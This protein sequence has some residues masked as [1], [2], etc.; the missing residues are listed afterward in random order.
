MKTY[1][2][3]KKAVGLI[4]KVDGLIED[5]A[6]SIEEGIETAESVDK[7]IQTN[8]YNLQETMEAMGEEE[9]KAAETGM[10]YEAD[11]CNFYPLETPSEY[12]IRILPE[13]KEGFSAYSIFPVAI[14]K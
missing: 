14:E 5:R 4:R 12:A 9:R 3:I 6:W 11:D 2:N 7:K 8:I 10:F 1:S 13:M